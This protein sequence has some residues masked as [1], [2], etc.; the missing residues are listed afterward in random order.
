MI[1]K[2]AG[3]FEGTEMPTPGWWEALWP[4]PARVVATAGVKTDIDVIDLCSGDGW[5][6]LQIAKIAGHVIA[7]DIDA[8]LL[9]LARRRLTESGVTNCTFLAGDAYEVAHLWPH[10]VDLVFMANAFHGVPDRL[11]LSRAVSTILKPTGRFSIVNWHQRPREET[12][13]LGEPRGPR[14]E[15]RL[16]PNETIASVEPAGLKLVRVVEVP[17]YHYAAI[18]ER[19]RTT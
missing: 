1:N 19:P 18:F 14:T 7:I 9:G 2:P 12:T 8:D 6:T 17:R 13:V 11:R 10:P 5:F 16:S 4:D 15:L 3:F